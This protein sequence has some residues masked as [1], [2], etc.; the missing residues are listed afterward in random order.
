MDPR[1]RVSL[2]LAAMQTGDVIV[3]LVSPKYGDA[4]LDHL[5]VA[6]WLRP[7]LPMI[8]LAAVGSLV[9]T[10]NRPRARS[11]TGAV[12]VAYYSAATTFHVLS[13]DSRADSAPA[14]AFGAV[15]AT[16]V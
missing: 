14:A 6:Q 11:V 8:K 12:L 1:R 2:V 9:V 4:H 15:A 16:I 13:G 3:T 5:G 10:S 7:M